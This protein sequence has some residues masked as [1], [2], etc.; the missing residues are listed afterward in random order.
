M[1]ADA[2]AIAREVGAEPTALLE[3]ALDE[4][5]MR[6]KIA[7]AFGDK[8]PFTAI[9]APS[10]NA[11]AAGSPAATNPRLVEHL[12]DMLFDL[13]ASRVDI[14]STRDSSALW[15][16]NR[17]PFMVAELLGY[18]YVTPKGRPYDVLDLADDADDGGFAQSGPLAGSGLSS[19]WRDADLRIIFAANR[20]DEDDGYA[21]CLS[22]L[23]GVLPLTDKDYHY[24][25]R[26]DP[27]AVAEAL[28]DRAPVD[29]ALID[30]TVSAHGDGGGRA[31]QSIVTDTIIAATDPTLADRYGALMMGLDPFIS[32]TAAPS[33]RRQ[34]LGGKV[35]IS[36]SPDPYPEWRNVDPM[37]AH[38]TALRRQSVS[39]DRSLRPILQQTDREL[40]PF[41][42]PAN[43]RAN[44]VLAPLF[45]G[46]GAKLLTIVN[47]WLSSAGA[48]Q[49]AWATHFDKDAVRRHDLPINIDPATV[50]DSFDRI[51]SE[52][53]PMTQLLRGVPADETGLRWRSID[54]AVHFDGVRRVPIPFENFVGAVQIH[55][56]ITYM[57]DYIGGSST[58]VACDAQQRIVRQIERNLYLPQPNYTI[59]F[60]GDVIDVTKIETIRYEADRQ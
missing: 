41:S 12:A 49:R 51:A 9:I 43:D 19:A 7:T 55:R 54:G 38:A 26:R 8:K 33:L 11:F 56:T 10:L 44:A 34:G 59:L 1:A 31:P 52:L 23:I 39:I 57:N 45:A 40:F 42:N 4:I 2:I 16:E 36:G 15:L 17:D 3:R 32:R 25:L 53:L 20:T 29:L 28:L 21:L 13:G 48:V 30:A 5:G 24:R 27:G 35:R 60:G 50:A 58:A 22:T 14:G 47:L 6:K 46:E 37:L 18:R